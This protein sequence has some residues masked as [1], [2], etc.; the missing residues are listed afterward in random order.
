[1]GKIIRCTRQIDGEVEQNNTEDV[2][3]YRESSENVKLQLK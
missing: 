2:I 1:M 3:S